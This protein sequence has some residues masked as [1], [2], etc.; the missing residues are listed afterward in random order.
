[1]FYVLGHYQRNRAGGLEKWVKPSWA[2]WLVIKFYRH[3]QLLEDSL[4]S[5]GVVWRVSDENIAAARSDGA[6]VI[7]NE[8]IVDARLNA[9]VKSTWQS[10]LG[11]TPMGTTLLDAIIETVGGSGHPDDTQGPGLLKPTRKGYFSLLNTHELPDIR[12]R[13]VKQKFVPGLNDERFPSASKLLR[14]VRI[15]TRKLAES[16]KRDVAEKVGTDEL[17]KLGIKRQDFDQFKDLVFDKDLELK[18]R[19][20]ETRYEDTFTG[21]NSTTVTGWVEVDGDWSRNSNQLLSPS[22]AAGYIRYDSALSS[23]DHVCAADAIFDSAS[24]AFGGVMVR[25]PPGTG[26]GAADGFLGDATPTANTVNVR[27]IDNTGTTVIASLSRTTGAETLNLCLEVDGS[28]LLLKAGPVGSRHI[29]GISDSSHGSNVYCGCG[30]NA[31]GV[32][33]DNWEAYDQIP[34]THIAE[35]YYYGFT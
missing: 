18:P 5:G 21:A 31:T 6:A 25:M 28:E 15:G 13:L 22:G 4:E 34:A 1:M 9:K 29:V 17:A 20:R 24:D 3:H 11:F 8:H 23:T 2:D 7:A 12:R 26:S 30:A 16:G 10:W 33:F 27:Q 19:K 35:P 14:A 32:R